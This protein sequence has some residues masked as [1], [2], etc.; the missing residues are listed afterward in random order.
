MPVEERGSLKL[1]IQKHTEKGVDDTGALYKQ[2]GHETALSG[3]KLRAEHK[4]VTGLKQLVLRNPE[5]HRTRA[6]RNKGK[7]PTESRAPAYVL[8]VSNENASIR[9]M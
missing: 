9:Q 7:T 8:V 5:L 4:E 1:M 6:I 2:W 3:S